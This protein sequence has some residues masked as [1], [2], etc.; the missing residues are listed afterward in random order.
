MTP[1]ANP[2]LDVSFLRLP[3]VRRRIGVVAIVFGVA[4]A[5]YGFLAPRWYSATGTFAPAKAPPG[6]SAALLGGDVANL[7]AAFTGQ[8]GGSADTARIAAVIQGTAV[9]DAVIEKLDLRRRYGASTQE[10]AREA[11]W[12][13]CNVKAVPRPN[14]VQ[15]TCEDRDPKFVRD[16]LGALAADGN[17]VFRRVNV[18]SASEEVR[19]LERRVAELRAQADETASRL[20]AFQEKHRIVDLESQ[21]KA[22]VSSLA[23]LDQQRIGKQMELDYARRYAT[24]DEPGARQLESQIAVMGEVL[25]ELE[26]EGPPAADGGGRG[27]F[28]ADR[29]V[30]PAALAVPELRADYEKLLRDRRVAEATLVFSLDRLEAAR[31]AE[32]RDVSTFVVVDPPTVPSRH[33]RPRK[34][35]SALA[36]LVLGAGVG[37]V[38]EWARARRGAA[39]A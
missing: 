8:G 15:L 29:G 30:F 36:G 34:L 14:L 13:H 5:A 38:L 9:S 35:Q 16:L 21:A 22:V 10:A 27:R 7:A 28:R 6:G 23:T 18:G 26:K 19:H 12:E 24:G 1:A 25:R 20:R 33:T 32:A 39:A 11:L 2:I 4:G 31:A 17:E 37:L 3:E